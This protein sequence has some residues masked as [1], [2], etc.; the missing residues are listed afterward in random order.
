MVIDV[1][2]VDV[3]Y[4]NVQSALQSIPVTSIAFMDS[5]PIPSVVQFA[6][7]EVS[8]NVYFF[9]SC[10]FRGKTV[11]PFFRFESISVP[12]RN[13]KLLRNPCLLTSDYI[14]SSKQDRCPASNS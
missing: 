10:N 12:Q 14:F 9:R 11:A 1:I 3:R 13:P 2:N 4:A 8:Q 6:S 5:K 7:V